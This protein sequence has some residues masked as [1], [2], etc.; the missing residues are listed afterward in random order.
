MGRLY[1]YDPECGF[2][3]YPDTVPE[4]PPK[5]H[6]DEIKDMSMEEMSEWIANW[7]TRCYKR[8]NPLV[9][10]DTENFAKQILDWLKSQVEEK[11]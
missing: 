11:A 9:D 10:C 3:P 2:V 5:T 6:F 4:K 8:V 1:Y 7:E